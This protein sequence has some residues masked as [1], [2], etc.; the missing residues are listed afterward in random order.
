L[1]LKNLLKAPVSN[2]RWGLVWATAP[3]VIVGFAFTQL[4]EWME[5]IFG[6]PAILATYGFVIWRKGFGEE[7]RL[8]FR[9][10]VGGDT[11]S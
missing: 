1:L 11:P 7:D 10:N 5:L 9:K 6:I 2:W 8:L 4:P 3:A